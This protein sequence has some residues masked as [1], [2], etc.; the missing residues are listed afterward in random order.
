MTTR[1]YLKKE[2]SLD[3]DSYIKCPKKNSKYY[4]ST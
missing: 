1:L 2:N 3:L 4:G